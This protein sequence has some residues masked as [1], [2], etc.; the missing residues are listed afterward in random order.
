MA[1]PLGTQGCRRTASHGGLCP[2][3]GCRGTASRAQ[4]KGRG[5]GTGTRGTSLLGGLPISQD[6]PEGPAARSTPEPPAGTQLLTATGAALFVGSFL[7]QSQQGCERMSCHS[8]CRLSMAV[9]RGSL[10][11]LN[12][13]TQGPWLAPE[14]SGPAGTAGGCVGGGQGRCCWCQVRWV[15]GPC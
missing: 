8:S 10:G 11:P 5:E 9:S 3:Q 4:P 1:L 15:T 2:L 6:C 7:T 13:L 12:A 14:G